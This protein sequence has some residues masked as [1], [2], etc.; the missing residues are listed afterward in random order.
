MYKEQVDRLFKESYHSSNHSCLI[1]SRPAM[2]KLV[3]KSEH[4]NSIE[5]Q[6]KGYVC[7]SC[8]NMKLIDPLAYGLR[9]LKGGYI[10]VTNRV[11]N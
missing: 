1:C 10:D 8:I 5:I 9:K 11:G 3:P 6:D 4:L 7:D 2:Y